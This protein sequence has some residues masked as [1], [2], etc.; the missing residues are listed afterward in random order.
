[1][2]ARTP[3]GD[4]ER[5]NGRENEKWSVPGRHGYQLV[6]ATWVKVTRRPGEL[7]AEIATTLAAQGFAS[8]EARCGMV[9]SRWRRVK[10]CGSPPSV[11]SQ[12]SVV[13]CSSMWS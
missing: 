3:A 8:I 5:N 2:R 4:D 13:S 7:L 9:A 12:K 11:A 6:L 1:L 10:P